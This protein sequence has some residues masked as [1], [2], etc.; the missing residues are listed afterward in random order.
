[1]SVD[2]TTGV[3]R[4]GSDNP[5]SDHSPAPRESRTPDDSNGPTP[6]GDVRSSGLAHQATIAG[7]RI[8]EWLSKGVGLFVL[9]VVVAIGIDL[10]IQAIPS[11]SK[12]NANFL[13]SS[14]VTFDRKLKEAL[15]AFRLEQAF[16]KDRILELYLN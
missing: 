11:I 3:S 10:L 4:S 12:D 7:D 13:L 6:Q 14:D 2:D 16:T 15:I 5:D 9:I 8:F 1:M